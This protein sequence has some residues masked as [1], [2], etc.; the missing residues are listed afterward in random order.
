MEQRRPRGPSRGP[1]PSSDVRSGA[2]T[3]ANS[4]W[5]GAP[6]GLLALAVG[7]CEVFSRGWKY[8]VF[9]WV[10]CHSCAA[11]CSQAGDEAVSALR[12]ALSAL[13]GKRLSDMVRK[14]A[15]E[16]IDAQPR[17]LPPSRGDGIDLQPQHSLSS[18]ATTDR[19]LPCALCLEEK[20]KSMTTLQDLLGRLVRMCAHFPGCKVFVY[21]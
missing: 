2:Y 8:S 1:G 16:I 15:L 4:S 11:R 20:A 5:T 18:A 19:Y 13:S 10:P 9:L 14:V 6:F 17:A 3:A 21:T 7:T 12:A